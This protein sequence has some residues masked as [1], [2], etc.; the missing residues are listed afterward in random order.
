MASLA[1]TSPKRLV[2]FF[3][4][5]AQ[6]V[7]KAV[8]LSVYLGEW[9]TVVRRTGAC[10]CRGDARGKPL[11]Y[12]GLEKERLPPGQPLCKGPRINKRS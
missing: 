11:L 7:S 5:M 10:L 12:R 2:M 1:T 9:G 6:T 4:S 3:N 8:I